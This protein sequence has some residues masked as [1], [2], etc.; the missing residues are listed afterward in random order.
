MAGGIFQNE[1]FHLNPKC[2]IISIIYALSY[3]YLPPKKWYI[4]LFI[5]YITYILIAWYDHIYKCQYKL[6]P[7]IFPF[8]KYIYLP[9]KPPEY[10]KEYA[11]LPQWKIDIMD[12]FNH[13]TL[14]TI[15]M[16]IIV[17]II[18]KFF[19]NPKK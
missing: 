1:G 8:G 12:K 4:L 19:I 7:T 2:I 10:Q 18:W 13:I 17:W 14:W 6:H 3:W 11:N 5:L 16:F 15:L 9:F